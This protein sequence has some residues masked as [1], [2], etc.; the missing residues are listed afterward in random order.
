V[1]FGFLLPLAAVLMLVFCGV[2]FWHTLNSKSPKL[3]PLAKSSEVLFAQEVRTLQRQVQDLTS[4]AARAVPPGAIQSAIAPLAARVEKLEQGLR[5]S[6]APSKEFPQKSHSGIEMAAT[7]VSC[8]NRHWARGGNDRQQL[9]RECVESGLTAKWHEVRDLE[10]AFR[11]V[12]WTGPYLFAESD[13]GGWLAASDGQ[14]E[15]LALPADPVFFQSPHAM[16]VVGKMFEGVTSSPMNVHAAKAMRP[17][18]LRPASD[19]RMLAVSRGRLAFD[20]PSPFDPEP[21]RGTAAIEDLRKMVL[22]LSARQADFESKLRT[23]AMRPET[24]EVAPVRHSTGLPL[25]T[26]LVADRA[27]SAG[28]VVPHAAEKPL[29]EG[30]QSAVANSADQGLAD[31]TTPIAYIRRLSRL[32]DALSSIAPPGADPAA[33]LIHVNVLADDIVL[34]RSDINIEAGE[35]E[36]RCNECGGKL[37]DQLVFQVFGALHDTEGY[38]LF[39]PPGRLAQIKFPSG[40]RLLLDPSSSG[41]EAVTTVLQ[42]ARLM[43]T[44]RQGRHRVQTRMQLSSLVVASTAPC[45]SF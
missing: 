43:P 38:N 29:P 13:N 17:C 4:A 23:L 28:T 19:G 45:V 35:P 34:H 20:S 11:S 9:L 1:D 21:R 44:G 3:D 8:V 27:I 37:G 25:P 42:P 36:I 18:L 5:S 15:L 2:F 31:S 33:E 22:R 39:F 12:G 14:G 10:T 7:F 24:I 41:I 16:A 30:W 40:Y 26:N 6:N 32:F